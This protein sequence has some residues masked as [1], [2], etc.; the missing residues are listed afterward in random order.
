MARTARKPKDDDT[1]EV[2]PKDYGLAKKLYTQDIK[3]AVAKAGE[4]M[5]E[6]STA[7][8]SIKKQANIQPQAAKLAFKLV[9]MEEAKRD[10]F[11]RSLGGLLKEFNIAIV[12]IDMVDMM[13]QADDGYARPRPSLVAVSTPSDGTETDL[14]DAGAFDEGDDEPAPG[15]GAA[16]IK[17]MKAAAE[18]D[19]S[20]E[21]QDD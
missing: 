3:P 19:S 20:S 12:P 13:Q 14:G 1:G 4:F 10:D 17:A 21:D 8:K 6:A 7:Y 2:K 5:Q 15:T 11:L 18:S 16:A 9:N